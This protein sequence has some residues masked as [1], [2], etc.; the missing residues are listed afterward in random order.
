LV[1]AAF[2]LEHFALEL[3]GAHD[4]LEEDVGIAYERL[5]GSVLLDDIAECVLVLTNCSRPCSL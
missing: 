1:P 3:F 5:L 4:V 2:E